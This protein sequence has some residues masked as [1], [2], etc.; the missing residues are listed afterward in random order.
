MDMMTAPCAQCGAQVGSVYK[1]SGCKKNMRPGLGKRDTGRRERAS[2]SLQKAAAAAGTQG[3]AQGRAQ[4]A[5]GPA[6]ASTMLGAYDSDSDDEGTR[7]NN[8]AEEQSAKRAKL[9]TA[10]PFASRPAMNSQRASA[11]SSTPAMA[12][13]K[14]AVE[15]PA[16]PCKPWLLL[17]GTVS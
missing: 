7:P 16:G 1:C 4:T 14:P 8:A 3:R 11:A 6:Q 15:E 12:T 17:S 10:N 9:P 13:E 5:A 2:T